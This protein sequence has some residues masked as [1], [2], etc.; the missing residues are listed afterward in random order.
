MSGITA[1][2]AQKQAGY[3]RGNAERVRKNG[4]VAQSAARTSPNRDTKLAGS[5]GSRYQ[6][7][8]ISED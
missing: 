5:A 3:A 4:G 8:I 6:N 2:T 7:T 1:S